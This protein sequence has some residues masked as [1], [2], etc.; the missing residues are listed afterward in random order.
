MAPG[1]P[2]SQICRAVDGDWTRV[3]DE[4]ECPASGQV[5]ETGNDGPSLDPEG[6]SKSSCSSLSWSM[7]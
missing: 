6:G 4:D 5:T 3:A 7:D 1:V 2:P